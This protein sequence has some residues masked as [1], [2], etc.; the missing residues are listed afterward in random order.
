MELNLEGIEL[1]ISAA[2]Y[3]FM[4]VEFILIGFIVFL[5]FRKLPK[6]LFDLLLGSSFIG[7]IALWYYL[8]FVAEWFPFYQ[9]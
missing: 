8:T 6:Q 4:F 5:F 9:G 1:S 3:Y 7:G 2:P